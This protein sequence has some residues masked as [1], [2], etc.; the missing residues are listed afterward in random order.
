MDYSSLSAADLARCCAESGH[1]AAWE[2]FVQR[3]HQVIAATV[4][5]T[6]RRW[7][8][9]SRAVLDD[10]IQEIYLKL[11]IDQCRLLREFQPHHPDAIFGY[12][13]VVAANAASDY[14][15]SAIRKPGHSTEDT[16]LLDNME[17]TPAQGSSSATEREI[18]IKEIGAC[19]HKALPAASRDRDC[20]IFWLHYRAGM[21]AR[22]I[23]AL[24]SIGLSTK[25]VESTLLRLVRLVRQELDETTA[26]GF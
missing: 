16:N 21:S 6:A 7:G 14:F 9:T 11:C 13:K 5:R 4:L 19:L 10:V 23:A 15:K 24:P 12:L 20:R 26:T 17:S 8:T 2:E 25:G 3:F 22:A 1:P 18:L